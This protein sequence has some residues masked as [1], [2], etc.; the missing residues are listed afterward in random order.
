MMKKIT[1]YIGSQFG[2]PR[3]IIGKVCCIIMNVINNAMYRN[4][5]RA[6][7]IQSD[8]K[9]LDIGYGNGYLLKKIYNKHH[10]D[11]YGI[12]I[13]VDMKEQATSRNIEAMKAGK[14]HLQ[15]GDCCNLPYDADTFSAVSSINTIYF[16]SDTIKGLSEINRVLKTGKQFFNAVYT[17]EWL[18]K[19][20]YTKE[21][22]KKYTPNEFI[23]LGK[24]AGFKNVE[25]KDIVKGKSIMVIYKNE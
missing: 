22:F 4:M 11:L 24:Q 17:K 18:D 12:D 2:N 3:G 6:I 8:E 5:V 13:S 20:S 7:K 25:V 9:V 10:A 14:L 15:V 1:K 21:G 16:W 23:E 19:L